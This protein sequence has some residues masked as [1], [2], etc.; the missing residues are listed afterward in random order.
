MKL[1]KTSSMPKEDESLDDLVLPTFESTKQR[2]REEVT[3]RLANQGKLRQ[4]TSAI[5]DDFFYADKAVTMVSSIIDET[6]SLIRCQ[7]ADQMQLYSESFFLLPM[8]RLLEGDMAGLQLEPED[9]KMYRMRKQ[10]LEV[11]EAE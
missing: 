5:P 6:F 7:V 9:S 10:V 3:N 4:K 8:L 11:E 1:L 2:I